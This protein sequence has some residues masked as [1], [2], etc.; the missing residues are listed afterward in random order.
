M[1]LRYSPTSP[2]VRKVAV[3]AIEAGLD[4]RI[5]R[6][7]TDV[8]NAATDI[9]EDNPLGKVPA[10]ITDEGMV[11]CDSPTICEYLDSLHDGPGLIPAEG[12]ARWQ[13]LNLHALASGIMDA[14]V[15]RIVEVRARPEALRFDGW[16]ERQKLKIGRALD[17]LEGRAAAGELG[18]P[19]TLGTITLGCALGYLDLRFADDAW[20]DGRPALAAWYET[21]SQRPSMQATVPPG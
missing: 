1:K 17:T 6:I 2:Y 8:W 20:R 21:F 7:E 3:V 9:A 16:L 5:E 11:L 4:E 18:G 12:P 13:V 14:A 15:A 19:I 10:L